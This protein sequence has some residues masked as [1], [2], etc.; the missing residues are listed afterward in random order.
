M[1]DVDDD[2]SQEIAVTPSARPDL[3]RPVMSRTVLGVSV[4]GWPSS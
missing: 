1:V 3:E 2:G 4:V